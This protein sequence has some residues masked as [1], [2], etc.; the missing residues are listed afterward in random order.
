MNASSVIVEG[1]LQP[2]GLTL[3]LEKKLAMP[4]GRVTVAVHPAKVHG[5]STMLETLDRILADQKNRNQNAKTDEETAAEIAQVRSEDD[6]A[7]KRWREIWSQT[8]PS[9]TDTP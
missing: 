4:P 3:R 9:S 2:D 5:G 8:K 7:E 1:M 6:E